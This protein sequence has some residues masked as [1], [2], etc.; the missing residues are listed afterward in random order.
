M[1]CGGLVTLCSFSWWVLFLQVWKQEQI[2]SGLQPPGKFL[3]LSTPEVAPERLFRPDAIFQATVF[4]FSIVS[5]CLVLLLCF[6]LCFYHFSFQC[7]KV[8]CCC[9]SVYS[10]FYIYV[11]GPPVFW[12]NQREAVAEETSLVS[13]S[14][15]VNYECLSS[16][17]SDRLATV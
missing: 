8:D 4:T 13:H 12:I 3:C 6:T 5:S 14:V 15:S 17:Y 2:G 7:I 10:R 16:R 11:C 1:A 9:H